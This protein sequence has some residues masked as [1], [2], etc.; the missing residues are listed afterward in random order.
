[1]S[2]SLREGRRPG[3]RLLE[4]RGSD[5][6]K[7]L[8]GLVTCDVG[9]LALGEARHGLIVARKGKILT[10]VLISAPQPAETGG[11]E[12]LMLDVDAEAAS[13]VH[14]HLEHHLIMEDVE[15]LALEEQPWLILGSGAHQAA[16]ER[17]VWAK[18]V[19]RGLAE[20]PTEAALTF[21][22]EQ[23]AK[24]DDATLWD[25]VRF[26]AGW[27]AF[28]TDYD[29][30]FYP[31]EAGLEAFAVAFD[32]GCYLGQ[33]VVFMLQVRGKVKRRLALLAG[34]VAAGAVIT[35]LEGKE[36][37]EART[38]HGDRAFALLRDQV[39]KPDTE[40]RAGDTSLRVIG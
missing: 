33:E 22:A 24:P 30:A 5:C 14:E 36:V 37:G 3:R 38:T 27:P 21:G 29:D 6:V 34:R 31:Q 7:W 40:L 11:I 39:W 9:K 4:V 35:T 15:I 20:D 12:R 26:S 1:M 28:R 19:L 13:A 10:D 8:N 2:D 17:G 16:A 18:L 23:V 32:K 25:D